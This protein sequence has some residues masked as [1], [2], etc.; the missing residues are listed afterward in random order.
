MLGYASLEESVL[1]LFSAPCLVNRVLVWVLRQL[2]PVTESENRE[3]ICHQKYSSDSSTV[4]HSEKICQ[5]VW[6]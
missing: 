3:N 6:R 1:S 2:L 5:E 4:P